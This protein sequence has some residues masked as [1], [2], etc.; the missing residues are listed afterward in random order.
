MSR[1]TARIDIDTEITEAD[2]AWLKHRAVI[3][4]A[5]GLT[6]SQ[7]AGK[8]NVTKRMVRRWFED[9]EMQ[10]KLAEVRND[11]AD[12]AIQHLKDSLIEAAELLMANA[13]RAYSLDAFSDS[14]RAAAEVLDRGGLAKVNKSESKVTKNEKTTFE[15]TEEFFDKFSTLPMENQRK[16]ADLMAEVEG[17]VTSGQGVG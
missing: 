8:L 7:I 2:L 12:G 5:G 13:R 10:T 4:R 15:G 6:S 11:I 17:L 9:K 14:I 1:K 3:L 16:I